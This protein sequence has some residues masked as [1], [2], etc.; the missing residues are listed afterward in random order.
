MTEPPNTLAHSENRPMMKREKTTPSPQA[1]M[2]ETPERK[3]R[4]KRVAVENIEITERDVEIVRQVAKH[5][6]L[7]STHI[8]ALVPG[9]A[10]TTIRRLQLLYHHQILDRPREQIDYYN[11]IGSK[12]I[13]YGLGNKGADLLAERM[14]YL[15]GKINW[16]AKNKSVGPIFLEHTLLT[17]DFM[18]ALEVACREHGRV[19]LI[20]AQ[21]ILAKAPESTRKRPNP[22]G[23]SVTVD[24]L[25]QRRHTLG[26]IPD[27]MFGLQY[28]DKPEGRNIGYFFL[29][30]DRATM[31][32]MRSNLRQTSFYRKLVTYYATWETGLHTKLFNFKNFR[33]LTVTSSPA[34]V[35]NLIEAN[36][37]FAKGTGSRIFLFTDEASLKKAG[38]PLTLDWQSG[39]EGETVRL[40]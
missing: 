20:D 33:V 39:R 26:V 27:Q 37:T 24:D 34:R 4:F 19:R 21:E 25:D 5:R 18:V 8:T 22:T 3:P 16:A 14:E 31:P 13:V 29:E 7:R 23:L 15:R 10:Q 11:P 36:K 6:F 32:V 28:L 35:A 12:A 9:S 40:V 1:P 38:N 17:A 2:P 30:A